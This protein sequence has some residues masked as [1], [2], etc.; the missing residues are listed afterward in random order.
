MIRIL[1]I[2]PV[3]AALAFAT[4]AAPLLPEETKDHVGETVAVRGLLEQVS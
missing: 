4:H 3:L 1:F 2:I